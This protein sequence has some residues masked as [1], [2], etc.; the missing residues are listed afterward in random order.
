MEVLRGSDVR[1][2]LSGHYHHALGDSLIL[3]DQQ[4][5]VLV[6]PGV[7]NVNDVLAPEGHERA[8]R[9]SGAQLVTLFAAP[10]SAVAARVRHLPLQ[11][12]EV[13]SVFD[14]SPEEV[15]EISGR[16]AAQ[17][18]ELEVDLGSDV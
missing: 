4:I 2:I 15:A 12:T 13:E 1:L 10:A 14:F 11:L 17:P 3:G 8:L 7:V 16:I 9:T 6:A 5:P 18:G